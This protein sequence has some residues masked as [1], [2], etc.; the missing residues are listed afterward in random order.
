MEFPWATRILSIRTSCQF[1]VFLTSSWRWRFHFWFSL[2]ENRIF[3][4]VLHH[5]II[6]LI[7]WR[8]R[9]HSS[10]CRLLF[11]KNVLI[12]NHLRLK[13][14][15]WHLSYSF[16]LCLLALHFLTNLVLDLLILISWLF[17]D[18]FIMLLWIWE[19]EFIS[20]NA[21]SPLLV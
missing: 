17:D 11:L 3:I 10:S 13:A 4:F 20:T 14:D 9:V 8:W 2:I 21:L 15:N 1:F 7:A 18:L 5:N 12:Q 19:I 16:I 6:L